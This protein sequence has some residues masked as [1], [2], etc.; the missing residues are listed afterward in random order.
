MNDPELRKKIENTKKIKEGR[1]NSDTE[2]MRYIG[3]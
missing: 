1:F 2:V 3:D